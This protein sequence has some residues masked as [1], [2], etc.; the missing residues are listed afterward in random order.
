M[1][2]DL[3]RET[4]KNIVWRFFTKNNARQADEKKE[5]EKVMYEI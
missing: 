2:I 5:E 4:K 1:E 3:R